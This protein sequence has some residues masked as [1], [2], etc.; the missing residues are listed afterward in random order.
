MS[1]RLNRGEGPPAIRREAPLPGSGRRCSGTCFPL[2][3]RWGKGSAGRSFPVAASAPQ[4]PLGSQVGKSHRLPRGV[5]D[6]HLDSAEPARHQLRH[7]FSTRST[8]RTGTAIAH[9]GQNTPNRVLTV[10][11][12]VENRVALGTDSQCAGRIHADTRI[13]SSGGRLHC[14]RDTARLDI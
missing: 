5:V 10:G 2:R 14:S 11:D 8:R 13:D 1:V 7:H 12:H 3:N 9:D 6:H 4:P